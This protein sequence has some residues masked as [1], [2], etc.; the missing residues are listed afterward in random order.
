MPY[1]LPYTPPWRDCHV[2]SAGQ[3]RCL[4]VP[5]SGFPGKAPLGCRSQQVVLPGLHQVVLK[6]WVHRGLLDSSRSRMT[7]CRQLAQPVG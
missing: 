2:V 1:Q 5:G 6:G 4:D 7:G 3:A